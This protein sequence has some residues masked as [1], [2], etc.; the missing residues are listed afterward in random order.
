MPPAQPQAPA[1]SFEQLANGR[2]GITEAQA[3]AY[4]PLANDFKY[5]DSNHDG[6][7]SKTEYARWQK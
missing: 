3:S 7:I 5:A 6:R 2:G 4:P 1:P